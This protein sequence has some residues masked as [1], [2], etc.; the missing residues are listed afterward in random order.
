MTTSGTLILNN[1]GEEINVIDISTDLKEDV[2]NEIL[3]EEELDDEEESDGIYLENKY[4]FAIVLKH[5]TGDINFVIPSPNPDDP[6]FSDNVDNFSQNGFLA[7]FINYALNKTEWLDEYA[8]DMQKD[9]MDMMQ[10]FLD[11]MGE[12]GFGEDFLQKFK[13]EMST[14]DVISEQKDID[15]TSA[16]AQ[17]NKN[18][19]KIIT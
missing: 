10:Q 5:D 8:K 4:D 1:T 14:V 9:S 6:E 11:F 19:P 13:E 16:V 17:L 2:E 12:Q 7:N 15:F 18:K 3:D